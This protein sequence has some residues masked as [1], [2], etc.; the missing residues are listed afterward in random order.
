M[1]AC[2]NHLFSRWSSTSAL[3]KN[4]KWTVK[5]QK[6][7]FCSTRW[8]TRALQAAAAAA[9]AALRRT[10]RPGDVGTCHWHNKFIYFHML[11]IILQAKRRRAKARR[12]IRRRLRSLQANTKVHRRSGGT[13]SVTWE[14]S[15]DHTQNDLLTG[16]KWRSWLHCHNV[17]TYRQETSKREGKKQEREKGKARGDH[18]TEG[19]KRS[20]GQSTKGSFW[21][22]EGPLA[23]SLSV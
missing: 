19:S 8:T 22:Q 18:G 10:R 4:V 14:H 1:T 15:P 5:K 16:D 20:K 12:R 3:M 6:L 7:S 17:Q 2:P 9:K 13:N 21:G 11:W 23:F